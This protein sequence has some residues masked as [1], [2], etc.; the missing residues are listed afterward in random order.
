MTDVDAVVNAK[1]DG[2]DNVDAGDDVD[3]DVPEVEE[4]DDVGE[5]ED[6]GQDHQNAD[7]ERH[8]GYKSIWRAQQTPY[9]A[10]ERE[11]TF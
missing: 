2:E 5:G 10:S 1:A 11:Q 3:G 6:D 9:I 7:P 8:L 4:P